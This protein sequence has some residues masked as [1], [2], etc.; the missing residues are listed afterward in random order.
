MPSPPPSGRFAW[1]VECWALDQHS[2]QNEKDPEPAAEDFWLVGSTSV[3]GDW[4][5]RRDL[6]LE[7]QER[8]FAF[9]QAL[10]WALLAVE[11]DR[12]LAA[13]GEPPLDF[14]GCSEQPLQVP[15]GSPR[16]TPIEVLEYLDA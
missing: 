12:A 8:L 4:E 6:F 3:H 14:R 7:E 9:G 5:R 16:A 13:R 1:A 2:K 10:W 15:P 11:S